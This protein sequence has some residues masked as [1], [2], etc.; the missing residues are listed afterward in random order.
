MVLPPGSQALTVS[1]ADS[2]GFSHPR[3]LWTVSE[4]G[5]TYY[6][7][8]W[9]GA[10]NNFPFAY[11][12][13]IPL[14]FGGEA[15]DGGGGDGNGDS[16]DDGDDGDGDDGDDGGDGWVAWVIVVSLVVI[17]GFVLWRR[18]TRTNRVADVEMTQ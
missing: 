5:C 10:C 4:I 13:V 18:R 9:F 8:K 15:G 16:G 14:E 3:L 7:N 1:E 17:V 2:L 12:Q 11:A 6:Q